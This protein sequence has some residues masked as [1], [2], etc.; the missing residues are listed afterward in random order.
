M[1]TLPPNIS[2]RDFFAASIPG[3]DD[4]KD[5]GID[6]KERVLGRPV[7]PWQTDPEGYVRWWADWSAKWRGIVADSML[8]DSVMAQFLRERGK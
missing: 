1:N 2:L 5:F 3:M 6:I 4:G 7:P 8:A